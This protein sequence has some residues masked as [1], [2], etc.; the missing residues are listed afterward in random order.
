MPNYTENLGLTKPLPEEFYDINVQNENMDKIDL[1]AVTKLLKATQDA[2]VELLAGGLQFL[3]SRWDTSTLN[4]PHTEGHTGATT[5]MLFTYAHS[6][7]Y[8]HQ[9]AF[10]SAGG[11][12]FFRECVDGVVKKWKNLVT[13]D[14]AVNK[15]G[16][17]MTDALTVEKSGKR[18][19]HSVNPDA[20]IAFIQYHN[21]TD[22]RAAN[23]SWSDNQLY[24]QTT[25]DMVS[26]NKHPILHT[27]NI[28]Q[29][30]GVAPATVE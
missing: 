1:G 3:T 22:N 15:A 7:T 20:D 19:I 11:G 24:Y 5:G 30:M 21:P 27:G 23:I 12:V 18:N 10:C 14:Y 28:A 17:T 16:D 29:Y 9:I 2:N 13:A 6:A 25:K 8:G 4:T 26:W